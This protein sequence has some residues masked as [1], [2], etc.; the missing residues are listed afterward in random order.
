MRSK[1][2]SDPPDLEWEWREG[3]EKR[4]GILETRRAV[5]FANFSFPPV[6]R[7]QKQYI[8]PSD[9]IMSPCT[10]KLSAYK[11]RQFGK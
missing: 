4:G 7:A 10:A 3:G 5:Q 11:S 9:T 1:F 8:S 2:S 6:L